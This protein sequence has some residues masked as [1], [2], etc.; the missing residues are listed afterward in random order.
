MKIYLALIFSC[1]SV[2]G[3]DT[4]IRVT[5]YTTTSGFSNWVAFATNTVSDPASSSGPNTIT[6]QLPAGYGK[7]FIQ[8][9]EVFTRDGQTNLVRFTESTNGTTIIW[10]HHFFYHDG[11]QV[12]EYLAPDPGSLQVRSAAGSPYSLVFISG[13]NH[14]PDSVVI[15]D[16]DGKCVDLFR[17]TN[18]VFSP[19]ENQAIKDYNHWRSIQD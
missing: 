15:Q 16:K 18:R 3:A 7:L 8:K 14:E 11:A 5:T 12:G 13:P 10:S 4:G 2:L 9:M 6:P 1:A 19:V 17:Y